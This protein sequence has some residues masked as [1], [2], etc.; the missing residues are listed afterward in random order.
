MIASASLSF[1]FATSL[2][3]LNF[4]ERLPDMD[5]SILDLI[6]SLQNKLSVINERQNS[7]REEHRSLI[8][9]MEALRANLHSAS[10][11]IRNLEQENHYLRISHKLADS[12]DTLLETR[13]QIASLIRRLDSSIALLKD[14]PAT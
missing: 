5:A 14:D 13:R 9:Q 4:V 10:E 7:L 12:P 11:R 2:F 8:D 1:S 3:F 6:S